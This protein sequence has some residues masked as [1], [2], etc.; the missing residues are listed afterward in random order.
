MDK[1]A[2]PWC[3]EPKAAVEKVEAIRKGLL[4]ASKWLSNPRTP[5]W[6][7]GGTP[8]RLG[9]RTGRLRGTQLDRR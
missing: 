8:P 4:L 6:A 5:A 1:R 9:A 3:K 7:R 2:A